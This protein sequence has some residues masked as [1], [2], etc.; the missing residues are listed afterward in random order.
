MLN[1]VKSL[2]FNGPRDRR[3]AMWTPETRALYDRSDLR[4]SSDLTDAEW[5]C[6][7]PLIPPGKPGGRRRKV[8]LRAV[9]SGI[10]Y[11]LENGCKWRSLPDG[12]PPRSTVHGYLL[13]WAWDGTLERIHHE[14]YVRTR[15]HQGREASPSAAILDNQSVRSAEKEAMG[16]ATRVKHHRCANIDGEPYG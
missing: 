13:L 8:D 10:L 4:F 6:L 2:W 3:L 7:A 14:L 12:F 5:E 1:R 11:V 9:L 16:R 15:G